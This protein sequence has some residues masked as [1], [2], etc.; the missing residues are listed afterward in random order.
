[1]L[2]NSYEFVI[3]CPIVIGVYFLLPRKVKYIWLLGASY[4]FYMCWNPWYSMLMALSTMVTYLSGI[5]LGRC[6]SV[7][8]ARKR[9][10]VAASVVINLGILGIFKYADFF[11]MNVNEL[12]GRM[13]LEWGIPALNILLPVGISFYTFQALSYTIDVY[14]GEIIPEKNLLRY[15]L[16]VSFF[17]QLVAGPIERSGNLLQQMKEIDKR[18]LWSYDSVVSGS[19]LALWGF[20]QKMVIA[21]R[22]ALLVDSIW[23]SYQDYGTIMLIL[24]VAGFSVQIYCDFA[25]Y[26]AI[27]IGV[28]KIMGIKLMENFDTPYFARNIRDFW[29]RWHISLSSWFKDYLYIPL[30]GGKCSKIRNYL[31][32]LVTFLISGLWHG[33][34][35]HFVLWGGIH[36]IYQIIGRMLNPIKKKLYRIM[37]FKTDSISWRMGECGVTFILVSFAWI[38]FRAESLS[39]AVSFIHQM[40]YN[41]DMGRVKTEGL[42]GINWG[43][44]QGN[45]LI[46]SLVLLFLASLIK[47]IT[48]QTIDEFLMNQTILFRWCSVILLLF[49]IIIYGEYGQGFDAQQFVY[50][51]F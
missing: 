16:F 43:D 6:T 27:A 32:L 19:I 36:G 35:W 46:I 41:M 25:G 20:F 42:Y 30:G 11:F 9:S 40:L 51:Q 29:K 1:M 8:T 10:I 14:R 45:I 24:A 7:Q 21:D 34:G 44:I 48:N 3:F 12:T 22:L 28:S 47:K 33:A 38:F 37:K 4:Y 26:S 50:F 39:E 17:P 23:E 18:R 31:N 49:M 13:G 2:F 5:L 15:A